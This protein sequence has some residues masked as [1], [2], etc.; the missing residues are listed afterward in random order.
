MPDGFGLLDTV[1]ALPLRGK[2]VIGF[3]GGG[4]SSVGFKMAT[5]LDP[6]ACF[7]HWDIAC[8]AH[9]RHFPLTEHHIAKAFDVDPMT[10]LAGDD[11]A[12][13]WFSPDCT[14]FS[15]AKGK[16]PRSER[17]RGLAWSVIPW[18]KLRRIKVI[19]LEN[20]EEFAQW[21]PVYR[22]GPKI[23][24][25]IPSRRGETFRRWKS[26][27]EQIGYVVEWRV[28]NAADYGAPTTR[29]RLYLVAR[30]DGRPIVWPARTHA[31][32]KDAEALGL[33]PWVGANTIINWSIDTPSIFMEQDE[34]DDLYRRTGQRVRR[35]L[36]M[37]T[38]RRI[39][40]GMDRHVIRAKRAFTVSIENRNWGGDR[41]FDVADPLGTLT[42]SKG[43]QYALV[44][45]KVAVLT[46]VGHG[47][48]NRA[49][50]VDEP[51]RTQ[52]EK[53]DKALVA[54]ALVRTNFHSAAA[55]NGV[56]DPEDPMATQTGDGGMALAS[57]CLVPSYSERPGQ[58]PRC[59]DIE[60]PV[61]TP[62]P[63]G[64]QGRLTAAHLVRQFGS[65]VGGRD[66]EDP[67][68]ASMPQ[69]G[70]GGGKD[71]LVT[72][73]M[74]QDNR[75]M[76][77]RDAEAPVTTQTGRGTQQ[78]LIAAHLDTYYGCDGE[79]GSDLH[80]PGRTA[81]GK[82]RFSLV[83][84]WLEQANTGMIGHDLPAPVS[85]IVGKGCTQRL[86]EARLELDGGPIGRRAKVLEF[87]WTH[88]GVPTQAEWAD[89]IGTPEA[90]LKFGLVLIEGQVWMI[91]DIGLRMLTPPELAAAMGLPA[92]FD[93]AT[94]FFGQAVSKT[95]QTQMIGNMV[96][97][98]PACALIAAN[99][100]DLILPEHRRAA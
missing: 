39:A 76:P 5:G 49:W 61:P 17:I 47:D 95:H 36:V 53:N 72:A 85:T 21:G 7:N 67:L 63:G 77:G 19:M 14:D 34:V 54:G 69:G 42:S 99:C 23:G 2:A 46:S 30:C 40:R 86:I 89:P 73:F 55:R 90:R 97:P 26:R 11:I 10:T 44:D 6:D 59:N 91:V 9:Q 24:E 64:N 58:S 50:P 16:A 12:F 66:I 37:A 93:L 80:E 56:R 52:T 71:Q 20:V 41:A 31:P 70:R 68:G 28:L 79:A 15:K 75:G 38:H 84:S 57:A 82:D 25:P 51:A 81:S 29:K 8:H 45:P 88:F 83:A 96:S 35:P 3:A 87:F 22:A 100:P 13:G 98:P 32:R 33:K 4:G 18:A 1:S 65:A 74:A 27:L 48:P 92:G 78:Q 60:D 43:G 62:V 94:N